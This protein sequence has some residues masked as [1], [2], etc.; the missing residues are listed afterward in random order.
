MT[1]QHV[2]IVGGGIIGLASAL[3]LT[4]KGFRVTVL[5]RGEVGHG[6]SF[7]N[8]GW[9]TPAIST[10]IAA[11]GLR[12][13]G[14]RWFLQPDS[15]LYVRASALPVLAPWLW[16]FWQLCTREA[17]ERGAGLMM[18]F[19]S[20][21]VERYQE[22]TREL[23]GIEWQQDGLLMLFQSQRALDA[24]WALLQAHDYGP[25]ERLDHSATVA[26]EPVLA[27]TAYVGAIQLKNEGQVEP[28]SV[29]QSLTRRCCALGVEIREGF[30][31][32]ELI[33]NS[34]SRTARALTGTQSQADRIGKTRYQKVEIEA[35]HIVI[36]AGA[37]AGRLAAAC[38]FRIPLQAG[39]GYSVSISD[40]RLQIRHPL[41][42]TEAKVAVSPFQAALRI[43]GTLELSGINTLLDRRRLEGIERTA[44][45]A[46]PGIMRG[47]TRKVWVGMRPMTPDGMPVIGK[48]PGADNVWLNTAHQMLGMTLAPRSAELLTD[49]VTDQPESR[50][51]EAFS[52]SRF[53]RNP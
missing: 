13:R 37:E 50:Y 4:K 27:D 5:E 15:P 10:P 28:L 32:D 48:L 53:R 44:E 41:Y 11:P 14:L 24:E 47:G 35:D 21:A 42:L 30:V 7:G 1:S 19:A 38:G 45:R 12:S 51:S 34:G 52:P 2:A 6:C 43:A 36:A 39:K 16:Q 20:D 40:P 49:L 31:A 26:I 29:C 46:I 33:F 17:F 22:W 18:P 8:A 3:A 9:V 25:I 23:E